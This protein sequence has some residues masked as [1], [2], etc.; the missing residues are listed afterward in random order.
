M[1]EVCRRHGGPF[2]RGGA[3]S[4]YKRTPEPHYYVGNTYNSKRVEVEDMTD[5]EIRQYW[6]GYDENQRF[7]TFKEY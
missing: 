6:L 2:D 1:E 7:G 5:Q 4:W 3:D